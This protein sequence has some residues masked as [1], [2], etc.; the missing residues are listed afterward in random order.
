MVEEGERDLDVF[1]AVRV[2]VFRLQCDR[3]GPIGTRPV[4]SSARAIGP[5]IS[6]RPPGRSA[7]G[8]RGGRGPLEGALAFQAGLFV[9]PAV[10]LFL[11]PSKPCRDGP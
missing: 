5:G 9:K 4:A 2:R 11:G 10:E 3:G 8:R 7:T 6:D 1:P